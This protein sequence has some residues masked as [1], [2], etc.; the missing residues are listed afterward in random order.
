MVISYV[1][2]HIGHCDN[3]HVVE[4]D[5]GLV[6]DYVVG[7]CGPHMVGLWVADGKLWLDQVKGAYDLLDALIFGVV[8]HF[9]HCVAS[10]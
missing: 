6:S 5:W 8:V 10:G 9:D 1:I 4:G 3:P 7:T 2:E